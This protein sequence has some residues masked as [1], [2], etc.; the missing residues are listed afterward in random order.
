[1]VLQLSTMFLSPLRGL[2]G[3]APINATDVAV[4]AGGAAIPLVVN[5]ASK[6]VSQ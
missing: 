4:I 2:L 3:I 1:M 5:E 6:K